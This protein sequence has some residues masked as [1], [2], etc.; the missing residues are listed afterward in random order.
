[1]CR[2]FYLEYYFWS[3]PINSIL[4]RVS[5]KRFRL[6]GKVI[7]VNK[8]QNDTFQSFSM[9]FMSMKN[10][11]IEQPVFGANYIKGEVKAEPQGK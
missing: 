11:D 10:L 3:S 8:N 5:F 4:F 9:S 7:F 6:F 1:M 2:S